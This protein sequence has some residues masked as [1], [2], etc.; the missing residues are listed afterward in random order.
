MIPIAFSWTGVSGA[1]AFQ[2]I[3][4]LTRLTDHR[5]RVVRHAAV[6]IVLDC[7]GL[8]ELVTVRLGRQHAASVIAH[9]RIDVCARIHSPK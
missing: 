5:K 9:S 7:D 6:R 2:I 8:T 3:P 4:G 1:A